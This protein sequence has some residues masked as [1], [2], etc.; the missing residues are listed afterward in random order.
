MIATAAGTIVAC[1]RERMLGSER[2]PKMSDTMNTASKQ[3]PSQSSVSAL[4]PGGP[5]R[6]ASMIAAGT[7]ASTFSQKLKRHPA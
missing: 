7:I 6:I 2:S 1:G 5:G 4:R 3:T